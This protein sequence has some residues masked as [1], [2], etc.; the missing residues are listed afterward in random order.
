MDMSLY[1]FIKNRKRTLSETR[2]KNFLFQLALGLNHLHR[3][4]IFHRDIKP[5]NILI[6]TNSSLLLEKSKVFELKIIKGIFKK[7]KFIK[8]RNYKVG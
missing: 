4:G 7:K 1:D 5:E 3:N 6:K 8:G 2:V